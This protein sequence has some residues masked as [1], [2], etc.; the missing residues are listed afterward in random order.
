MN[1]ELSQGQTPTLGQ[2]LKEVRE[3]KNLSPESVLDETGVSKEYLRRLEADELKN[4]S[5]S[6]LWKLA[7]Y[8]SI[9]FKPLAVKAGIIIKTPK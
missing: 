5:A 7:E 1:N 9:D 8:Y 3:S 6:V 4:T 2:I